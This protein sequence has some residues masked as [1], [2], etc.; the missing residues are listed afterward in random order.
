M[1]K[2]FTDI[3]EP[4]CPTGNSGLLNTWPGK[5]YKILNDCALIFGLSVDTETLAF[6]SLRIS[7]LCEVVILLHVFKLFFFHSFVR[8]CLF[9]P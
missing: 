2:V 3:L 6:P 4:H 8:G 5:I 9:V 7:F 1:Y